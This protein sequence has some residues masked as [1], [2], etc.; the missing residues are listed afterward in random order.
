MDMDCSAL[1]SSGGYFRLTAYVS[2]RGGR[3]PDLWESAAGDQAACD[4]GVDAGQPF[5]D[6]GHHGL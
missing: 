3:A 4:G 2:T 1:A 6:G 5:Q